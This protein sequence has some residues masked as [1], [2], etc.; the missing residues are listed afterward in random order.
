MPFRTRRFFLSTAGAGVAA[1]LLA[2][3]R[4]SQSSADSGSK[5]FTGSGDRR[6]EELRL[7]I[8]IARAQSRKTIP[9]QETNG[10]SER[11]RNRH[12]LAN[13]SKAFNHD[14]FDLVAESDYEQLLYAL[15][16]GKF[17]DFEKIPLGGTTKLVDPMTSFAYSLVGSDP[18]NTWT[19]PPPTF[20]SEEQARELVELYWQVLTRDIP[21]SEYESNALVAEGAA[22][23]TKYGPFSEPRKDGQVTPRNM[24]RAPFAGCLDGPFTS[25]FLWL[26]VPIDNLAMVQQ[27]PCF[28]AH[29]D[30][31]TDY[32][33]FLS[34]QN[35]APPT[36]QTQTASRYIVSAR[37]VCSYVRKD[38]AAEAYEN[39]ALILASFGPGA[40]SDSNPYKNSKTQSGFSSY[41]TPGFLDWVTQAATAAL[42]TVWYH[43][44]VI[45]RR[46][47]P[48]EFASRVHNN[49]VRKTDF[50]ISDFLFGSNSL[51][52]IY[53]ANGTYLLPQAYPEGCPVHPSYPAAHAVIA[54]AC[55][56]VLKALFDE[57]FVIPAPVLATPPGDEIIPY[58]IEPL[59]VGGE[60]NK[61][62]GNIALARNGAGVHWRSDTL[63]GIRLGERI[64]KSLLGDLLSITTDSMGPLTFHNFDGGLETIY[65]TVQ[66]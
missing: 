19:P 42:N 14:A 29:T 59:T 37:D 35:G 16:T 8:E 55:V 22:D 23:L 41:G 26:D 25:Q 2:P 47:R 11:Y 13:F 65:P 61:L 3:M 63:E 17:S 60:L 46:I 64:A 28:T 27:F 4:G 45:H 56:T 18:H 6:A 48:E 31:L 43:K 36:A 10:D 40:L 44:W 30:Y 58:K 21:F 32:A 39:A 34:V 54:G 62:A 50:P 7:R 52:R 53:S 51:N 57:S 20:A 12:F 5:S 33:S 1:G 38:F 9:P 66:R 49:I 24:F 15:S